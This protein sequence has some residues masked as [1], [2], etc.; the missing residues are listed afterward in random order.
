MLK[1]RLGLHKGLTNQSIKLTS[2][3]DTSS[4]ETASSQTTNH[5]TNESLNNFCTQTLEIGD[6][7]ES[8]YQDKVFKASVQVIYE[9][10]HRLANEHQQLVHDRLIDIKDGTCPGGLKARLY[11]IAQ[12]I[13]YPTDL[14]ALLL[15]YRTQIASQLSQYFGNSVHA[16]NSLLRKANDYGFIVEEPPSDEHSMYIPRRL[17]EDLIQDFLNEHFTPLILVNDLTDILIENVLPNLSGWHSHDVPN[18]QQVHSIHTYL[19]VNIAILTGNH[20]PYDLFIYSDDYMS[21]SINKYTIRLALLD[22]LVA[23]HVLNAR[24]RHEHEPMVDW[25]FNGDGRGLLQ[26]P[27]DVEMAG[28]LIPYGDVFQFSNA[29]K[30]RFKS[31]FKLNNILQLLKNV[32][33]SASQ[34]SQYDE[35]PEFI[36]VCIHYLMKQLYLKIDA[37]QTLNLLDIA[38]IVDFITE[39]MGHLSQPHQHLDTMLQPLSVQPCSWQQSVDNYQVPDFMPTKSQ[40]QSQL[41]IKA[42]VRQHRPI[43]VKYLFEDP[44]SMQTLSRFVKDKS[45]M[46]HVWYLFNLHND[47][48]TSMHHLKQL[49]KH[50]PIIDNSDEITTQARHLTYLLFKI[51]LKGYNC[52]LSQ[53]QIVNHEA[54]VSML[55]QLFNLCNDAEQA[56]F[57]TAA[58][59]CQ[60]FDKEHKAAL[61]LFI[62]L[63]DGDH[64]MFDKTKVWLATSQNNKTKDAKTNLLGHV[65][66]FKPDLLNDTLVSLFNREPSST[67]KQV[68]A[69]FVDNYKE[70]DATFINYRSRFPE[71]NEGETKQE[72]ADRVKLRFLEFLADLN[73]VDAQAYFFKQCQTSWLTI[74]KANEHLINPFYRAIDTAV[75]TPNGYCFF[76]KCSRH[77]SQ[78]RG[79]LAQHDSCNQV[80]PELDGPGIQMPLL[81]PSRPQPR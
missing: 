2:S 24:L 8:L 37:E 39:L 71:Q 23:L 61:S 58:Y 80:E 3:S 73:S 68:I 76:N 31:T 42:L 34:I 25:L 5:I 29:M 7:L 14:G 65:M 38:C 57:Y 40:L 63:L 53:Q 77:Q 20:D 1:M 70:V 22:K 62:L 72:Y 49:L 59:A 78:L 11:E 50:T 10:L 9:Q 46:M 19:G 41:V 15:Q 26:G 16:Y 18:E 47:L 75:G 13:K 60:K 33:F 52:G 4:N 69:T 74:I 45:Q 51:N 67:I 54:V 56:L 64:N 43:T 21:A 55:S 48:T 66:L 27:K 28:L 36:S 6:C 35:D 17:F 79:L 12:A 30:Y 81:T 44:L 32:H